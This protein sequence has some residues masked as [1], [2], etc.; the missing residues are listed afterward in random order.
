MS[1]SLRFPLLA[2]ELVGAILS[3]WT[4]T[5][6]MLEQLGRPPGWA[7]IAAPIRGLAGGGWLSA[8]IECFRPVAR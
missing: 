5:A 7:A 2:P 6:P 8:R 4:D 3:D 1:R